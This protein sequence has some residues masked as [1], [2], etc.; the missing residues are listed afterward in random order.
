M[1][2][3]WNGDF[4]D[5]IDLDWTPRYMIVGKDQNIKLFEAVKANDKRIKELLL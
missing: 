1:Q 3:G 4:G 5:F 2:S